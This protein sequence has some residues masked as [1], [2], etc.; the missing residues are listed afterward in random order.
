MA[1]TSKPAPKSADSIVTKLCRVAL[2]IESVEKKGFNDHH[3]YAYVREAELTAA[4]R[5]LLAEEGLWIIPA[6][7]GLERTGSLV[8]LK[9]D[10]QLIDGASGDVV[11]IPW[12]A[13]G[14]DASDKGINKALTNGLKYLLYKLLLLPAVGDNGEYSDAENTRYSAPVERAVTPQTNAVLDPPDDGLY[15]IKSLEHKQSSKGEFLLVTLHDGRRASVAAWDMEEVGKAVSESY[16]SKSP[17]RL[18][19]EAR[20][21]YLNIKGCAVPPAVTEAPPHPDLDDVPF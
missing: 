1:P 15:I 13:E 14:S 21:D 18:R 7:T 8:T 6:V 12:Y 20:G 19:I 3:K 10:F 9:M 2:K 11:H 4:A 16:T 17:C 5:G